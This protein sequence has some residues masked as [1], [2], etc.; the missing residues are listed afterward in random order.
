MSFDKQ[1]TN[2]SFQG[3]QCRICLERISL[4]LESSPEAQLLAGVT[5]PCKCAGSVKL[6]HIACLKEW[7]KQKGSI[8]CEICHSLYAKQWIE[9]AFEKNY[10]K[11]PDNADEDDAPDEDMY[12][13]LDKN[14]EGFKLAG[15]TVILLALFFLVIK[16]SLPEPHVWT[17]LTEDTGAVLFRLV[18][19][20]ISMCSMFFMYS[21]RNVVTKQ[22]YDLTAM[23]INI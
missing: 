8:Q 5:S 7:I 20:L 4:K 10:I 18:M 22:N 3:M 12:D 23:N 1:V 6:I 15:I 2:A 19:L 14:I 9:W 17:S 11:A 21:W 13:V 16:I